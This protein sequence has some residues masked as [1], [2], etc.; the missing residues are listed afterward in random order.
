[1]DTSRSAGENRK[2]HKYS[3]ERA[4][5]VFQQTDLA[6][7]LSYCTLSKYCVPDGLETIRWKRRMRNPVKDDGTI[8]VTRK[9][10]KSTTQF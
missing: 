8:T 2:S 3:T 1:M 5:S 4:R 9:N 10:I 7:N 6:F